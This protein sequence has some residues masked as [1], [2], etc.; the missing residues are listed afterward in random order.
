[1]VAGLE[2]N[3]L[4]IAALITAIGGVLATILA[5]RTSAKEAKDKA[6]EDCLER[7]RVSREESEKLAEELH[8]VKMRHWR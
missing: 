7:L 8:D 6:E 2:E 3:L 1:M 5:H 4:G